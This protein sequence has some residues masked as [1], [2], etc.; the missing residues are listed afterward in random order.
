MKTDAPRVCPWRGLDSYGPDD[1]P[2]LFG[3]ER[4]VRQLDRLLDAN[5]LVGVV[6]ASGSGKSSLLLAG[7]AS[8][9]Y[10]VVVV[11]PSG[12]PSAA[13]RAVGT[14]DPDTTVLVVDQ[15]EEI[16]SLCD[17]EAD[18]AGFVEALV[19]RVGAGQRVAVAL[20]SDRYGDCA[21]YPEFAELLSRGHVLLGSPSEQELRT[22][23][24]GPAGAGDVELDDELVAEI[25]DDVLGQTA[26]L[27][28]LSHA[29]TQTWA[30]SDGRRMGLDDYRGVGGVR[31]S[32]ALAAES[33]WQELPSDQTD[34]VRDVL[35][36]LADPASASADLGRR[37]PV[38]E[39]A[40]SGDHTRQQAVAALV[41]HRL[42][43][44][45]GPWI[46]I[47]HEA[48]FREWPRLRQWLHDDRQALAT[49][50][51][52]RE[53]ARSWD[54]DGRD[55]ANLLRGPRLEL[56][57]DLLER[58][59]G[60]VDA[61]ARTYVDMS[62][63][64][65]SDEL[66]AA[67]RRIA[68]Q[69]R[70]NRRLL[71]LVAAVVALAVVVGAIAVSA[72]RARD[73]ADVASE[74]AEVA[75]EIANARRLAAVSA[76]A[77]DDRLDLGALLAVESSLRHD[78]AD[79]RG[80][81]LAA[82][83]DRPELR[84]YVAHGGGPS[85]VAVDSGTG[86]I[87]LAREPGL[88]ELIDVAAAPTEQWSS[89]IG[90]AWPSFIRFMAD[91][92]VLIADSYGAMH[93]LDGLTGAIVASR[94]VA[95]E[96]PLSAMAV[97]ADEDLVVVGDEAGLVHAVDPE[98][99][100]AIAEPHQAHEGVVHA[101]VLTADGS[102]LI[103]GSDDGT[104]RQWS[105]PDMAETSPP[106]ELDGEVWS[107][108]LS[109]ADDLLAVGGDPFLVFVD[110]SA[111][112]V[113]GA[114]IEPHDG[115]VFTV[116]WISDGA[117]VMSSGENGE[118][119]FWD[120]VTHQPTRRSL[121]GHSASTTA[122]A[123][124][125]SDD[126]VVTVSEDTRTAVWDL[127]GIGGLATGLRGQDGVRSVVTLADGS[128]LTGAQDGSIARW[129][130]EGVRAGDP[131]TVIDGPISD[132]SA[133]PDGS[134]VALVTLDGRA[135]VMNGDLQP[136][137][138]EIVLGARSVSVD[139]SRDGRWMAA[140][141]T[142]GDCDRCVHLI[143]LGS[144]EERL[145]GSVREGTKSSASSAAVFSPDAA[146]IYTTNQ[147]GWIE[148]ASVPS[149]DVLWHVEVNR[150]LR[151]M[152]LSPDGST[153]AVGGTGGLLWLL[154]ASTGERTATLLGHRG[155]V[156][157]LAFDPTNQQLASISLEDS[158][159]RL[160]DL[161]NSLTI[162]VPI[163][164]GVS[165]VSHPAWSAD[166]QSVIAPHANGGAVAYSLSL[167]RLRSAACTL[168]GRALTLVEW[169]QYVPEAE[170]YRNACAVVAGR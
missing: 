6:G 64:A 50:H 130:A 44:V 92:D 170:G 32:I 83:V 58:W 138:A 137:A 128:M 12:E 22:M 152:A 118:V 115:I 57:R 81:L 76:S 36:A 93:R 51:F 106:I 155:R 11:R 33:M 45:D 154:D 133:T 112:A 142:D 140:V 28:L 151:S 156:G 161:S 129:S 68:Q 4:L 40:P 72:R 31:G 148:A 60:R 1:G 2:L 144:G 29:L 98:T 126:L 149:G 158:T 147:V 109:P 54:G 35:V 162:G 16:F 9:G 150:P 18:R 13:L 82:S 167:D 104:I 97:A 157:G 59:P 160:W 5:R 3:R 124:D 48:V 141:Q 100:D 78:D 24:Q 19:Q 122:V 75:A 163:W 125:E 37:S 87:A 165:T 90:E 38:T 14:L 79:T 114:P 20:R 86:H 145:I 27:P 30:R 123:I 164:L 52:V 41:T 25:I 46:E 74:Q 116:T 21:A 117:E 146:V 111:G 7:L 47:A 91:G 66:A 84:Y 168:A 113:V 169:S 132:L 96:T 15:M 94:I 88:I 8:L 95:E 120:P 108:A 53:G 55:P 43:T 153:L 10:R 80:A 77:R 73:K 121:R 135:L 99:L 42:V 61:L 39:V 67:E 85:G 131:V 101:A 65:R 23:V 17:D 105:M 71:V 134:V 56:A 159:L 70:Q 110:L 107:M 63:Q 136:S 69:R 26:V 89:S 166:G 127:A 119:A 143:D 102:R 139:V 49:V 62:L 34:A 103:T